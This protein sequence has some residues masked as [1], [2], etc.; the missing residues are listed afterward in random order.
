MLRRILETQTPTRC[1]RFESD[2]PP[3]EMIHL[4]PEGVAPLKKAR[5]SG[6]SGSDGDY[7]AAAA[8]AV[9]EPLES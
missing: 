7:P 1:S 5:K 3:K 6:G 8:L 2:F 9:T 4:F